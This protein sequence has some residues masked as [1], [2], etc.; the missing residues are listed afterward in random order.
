M[1]TTIQPTNDSM[2][3]K[4]AIISHMLVMFIVEILDQYD[5][6][7]DIGGVCVDMK[8]FGPVWGNKYGG[9]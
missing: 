4:T 6:D 9:V 7:A 2:H 3:Q 5:A 8:R 1:H